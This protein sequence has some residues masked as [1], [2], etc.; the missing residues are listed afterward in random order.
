LLNCLCDA[1]AQE[2]PGDL[3]HIAN[4]RK[5]SQALFHPNGIS[6]QW[7]FRPTEFQ[8]VP[9]LS[10]AVRLQIARQLY[11]KSGGSALFGA[12]TGKKGASP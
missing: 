7:N 1:A 4:E 5:L 12:P 2:G 6:G 8:K 11:L 9:Y 10:R 3:S